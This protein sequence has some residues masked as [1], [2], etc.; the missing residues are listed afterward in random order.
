[1][2]PSLQQVEQSSIR[3]RNRTNIVLTPYPGPKNKSNNSNTSFTSMVTWHLYTTCKGH[4]SDHV[5]VIAAL[6]PDRPT[7]W[8]TWSTA[9]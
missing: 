4:V 7:Y 5:T 3:E 6:G 9:L 1:P 8:W 2:R